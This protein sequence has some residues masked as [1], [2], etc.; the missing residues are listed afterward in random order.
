MIPLVAVM[1]YENLHSLD[2]E[3]GLCFVVWTEPEV[4]S[5]L[6]AEWAIKQ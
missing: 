4:P 6:D 1:E 2:F 3:N 5:S